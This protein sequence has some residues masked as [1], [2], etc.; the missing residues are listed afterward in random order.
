MNEYYFCPWDKSWHKDKETLLHYC[1]SNG[2]LK[3]DA[4]FEE[5][6]RRLV[7]AAGGITVGDP[8]IEPKKPWPEGVP[9]PNI[10]GKD[11]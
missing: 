8:T 10:F 7:A 9:K 2:W 11:L 1:I 5:L 4:D 3:E 6:E